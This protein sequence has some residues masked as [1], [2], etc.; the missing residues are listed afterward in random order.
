MGEI[1]VEKQDQ[2][3][4]GT[5]YQRKWLSWILFQ[6]QF[7]ILTKNYNTV[8]LWETGRFGYFFKISFKFWRKNVILYVFEKLTDLGTFS[9]SASNFGKKSA[10]WESSNK[11]PLC[12]KF[13][14]KLTCSYTILKK[15]PNL[16]VF[17]Q[18]FLFA[19]NSW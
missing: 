13:L 16:S 11:V 12:C 19:A 1:F 6:D 10:G 7:Q 9:R 18:K 17:F 14:V 2:L 5:V 8:C 3:K 15:Y 4:Y